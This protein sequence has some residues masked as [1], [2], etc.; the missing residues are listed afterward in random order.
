[1]NEEYLNFMK[2]VQSDIVVKDHQ[3]QNNDQPRNSKIP[4]GTEEKQ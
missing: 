4:E 2:R 1:L 3:N